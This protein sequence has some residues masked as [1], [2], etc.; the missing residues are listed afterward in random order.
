MCKNGYFWKDVIFQQILITLSWNWQS[1]IVFS[2]YGPHEVF[3]Y[4][5]VGLAAPTY[6]L[7]TI[8]SPRGWQF[9]NF[10]SLNV[11]SND[12][13]SFHYVGNSWILDHSMLHQ[14]IV[15]LSIMLVNS[16]I[17][18][19]EFWIINVTLNDCISFHY[20]HVLGK[21][22][23]CKNG[24]FW[25]DVIFQ[26][27]LIT[28]SWNWQSHIVFSHYG[29]HEVFWYLNV[30]LA[31]PTYFLST[32][33]SPR[34][35]QF[36]NFGSLNV[37]SNDCI[38]FHY[39]GNSWI[40]D[41]STLHQ[42]IVFISIMLAIHE[43]WI[44]QCYIKWL[45]FFPLCWQFMNFGSLKIVFHEIFHY[46]SMLLVIHEFWIIQCYLKWFVFLSIMDMFLANVGCVK[47]A[48]FEKM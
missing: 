24:Y 4:L 38:S 32:I 34:G 9:M 46:H 33:T 18:D 5:N 44:T 35:W 30:G 16:W 25:K 40:L 29:P 17:L 42:M 2:H 6:F 48:I 10:G 13:I 12:C 3:W 43:F 26:Q 8:T 45:Y 20:G 39:V 7:S 15:F 19:H 41:H 22:W 14:M 37:T 36:M 47:M 11:T 23:M 21:C 1:H 27:I 28:L 31:A